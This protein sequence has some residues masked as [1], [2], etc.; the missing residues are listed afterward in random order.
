ML[1]AFFSN[2]LGA[3]KLLIRQKVNLHK[4]Y[5]YNFQ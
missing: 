3:S 4:G 5:V 2:T 1:K